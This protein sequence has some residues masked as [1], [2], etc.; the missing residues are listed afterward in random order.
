[1]NVLGLFRYTVS[2]IILGASAP[3]Y[4]LVWAVWRGVSI[5]LPQHVYQIGDDFLYG[6]YQRMVVFFFEHCTGQKVSFLIS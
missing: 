6:L 3:N 2:V 1:M 5:V 4:F